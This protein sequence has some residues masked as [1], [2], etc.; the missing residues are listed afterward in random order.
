ML[1]NDVELYA[2]VALFFGETGKTYATWSLKKKK[3]PTSRAKSSWRSGILEHS[4]LEGT[5]YSCDYNRQ[6]GSKCRLLNWFNHSL[7]TTACFREGTRLTVKCYDPK[8]TFHENLHRWSSSSIFGPKMKR[9]HS[10]RE[11]CN[12]GSWCDVT[13]GRTDCSD[14]P[15]EKGREH[16]PSQFLSHIISRFTCKSSV[17]NNHWM[18]PIVNEHYKRGN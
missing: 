11:L 9:P 16:K 8:Q 1:L 10:L 6:H 18:P 17:I 12:R 13:R 3:N 5:T 4:Q 14:G 7:D 2:T 15:S